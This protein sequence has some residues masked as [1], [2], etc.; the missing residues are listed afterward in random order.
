M[1]DYG[2]LLYPPR[3]PPPIAMKIIDTLSW[4]VPILSAVLSIRCSTAALEKAII[5]QQFLE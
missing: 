2:P 5:M 3:E 4:M 1:V